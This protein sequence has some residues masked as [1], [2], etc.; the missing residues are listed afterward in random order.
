MMSFLA[1]LSFLNPLMLGA[2]FG[3]PLLWY[4]LRVTPPQ[5]K[6]IFF[7]AA[8]FVMGLK[9][10]DIM[11]SKT[12]WWILLVR[13]CVA[14]LVILGLAQP[15]LNA[16]GSSVASGAIRIIMDN[17]W[18]GA[19]NWQRQMASAEEI[20]ASSAREGREVYIMTTAPRIGTP[21]PDSHGVLS[22]S[23]ALSVL[24]GLHPQ[25]IPADYEGML[26]RLKDVQ[27]GK[28]IHSIWLSHGM[29]E[30]G[31]LRVTQ[32]LQRQG[33]L[34]MVMPTAAQ[35]PLLLR[36]A[37]VDLSA[38]KAKDDNAS[39]SASA[40]I[41]VDAA[42]N[43]AANIPVHVQLNGQ[44]GAVL[45]IQK[46]MLS[47][48]TLPAE[49]GFKMQ[50]TLKAAVTGFEINGRAGA[51]AKF[52]LDERYRQR[53]VGIVAPAQES[54]STPLVGAGFYLARALEPYADLSIGSIEDL[55]SKNV[56]MMILPD[57][58]AMPSETL[59]KLDQWVKDGGLLLRFSGENTAKIK[60]QFLF[61]VKLRAGGRSLSGALSWDKQQGLAPFAADSPLAGLD[62][63][64]NMSI[65]QQV[66][67]E[68][69]QDMEGKV[70]AQ[71]Q[72]GTPFITADPYERGLIV[73]VHTTATPEWSDFALSGLY[74]N[75]MRRLLSMAQGSGVNIPQNQTML[76]PVAVM[77]G[78]GILMRPPAGVQAIE[79]AQADKIIPDS[80]HPPGI[81]G[82]GG[83]QYALNLGTALGALSEIKNLPSSVL[84]ENYSTQ[85]E[86]DLMP[87][88]LL[89]ALLLLM[90]DWAIMI[91][92][93]SQ[94]IRNFMMRAVVIALFFAMPT[95]AYAQGGEE[96]YAQGLYLAYIKS[97]DIALDGVYQRGLEALAQE[98][99]RRT[100]VE[101][102]GVV[103]LNPLDDTLAFFPIIYWGISPRHAN[104]GS[105]ELQ[106]IQHYLD[107]GGTILFDTRDDAI[108]QN[109]NDAQSS[110]AQIL[111]RITSS[112]NVPPIIPIPQDHVLGRSF[113]LLD[114]F[115]GR[116]DSGT[117]WLEQ[118]SASGRDGVSS[119]IIGGNDWAAAWADHGGQTSYRATRR[120]TDMA[121]RFGINLV[122]YALTGNYKSDQ[123]HIPH[124]LERLGE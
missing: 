11:P 33:S 89:L 74:V 9:A 113:Y 101:P 68:P 67:A 75:M 94:S 37:K 34:R 97:G 90:L 45:D 121:M 13:L 40:K 10:Q 110:H 1:Q 12:P 119:V 51:G 81:Y 118:Q 36:P 92:M 58:A 100:S 124:I 116:Y 18:A 31:I 19:Q 62:I 22:A 29:D 7:P 85:H 105:K 72:D 79:A 41:R 54:D 8:R 43:I 49:V 78:S 46:I 122:M 16:S 24:R 21:L 107:H 71:L 42:P 6:R 26:T 27:S 5:P 117:L 102:A 103:G 76:E 83:F 84:I 28:T 61:P 23:E 52:L 93:N 32:E 2:L 66:L 59:D 98:L 112:L 120:Q 50:S 111:R 82:K 15:V 48:S 3:L 104:I 87:P 73:L 80:L 64:D 56:A 65:T 108:T 109:G 20:L 55:I 70:W 88:L 106:N 123:V 14:A 57:I 115:P 17:S 77:D 4:L 63:P 53:H 96:K 95:F 86:K 69:A 99:A 114:R 35:M 38:R 60:E 25:S 44:D 47:S 91:A 30:G 39:A